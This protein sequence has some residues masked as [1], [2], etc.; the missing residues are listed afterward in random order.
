V[1]RG[2]R[3]QFRNEADFSEIRTERNKG[4]ECCHIWRIPQTD[5]WPL[6]TH[7]HSADWPGDL[8]WRSGPTFISISPS[9]GGIRTEAEALINDPLI[10][11]CAADRR[12]IKIPSDIKGKDSVGHFVLRRTLL[13]SITCG[14]YQSERISR[15]RLSVFK[16]HRGDLSGIIPWF[17]FWLHLKI[18]VNFDL[19]L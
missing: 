8:W 16:S 12:N 4:S 9:S 6:T 7:F 10:R 15:W 14:F 17:K 1:A 18:E 2:W 19:I 3:N 11:L 5:G 13:S